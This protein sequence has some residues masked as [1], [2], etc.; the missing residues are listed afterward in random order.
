METTQFLISIVKSNKDI[1]NILKHSKLTGT[2]DGN[3]PI[4]WYFR[5]FYNTLKFPDRIN[6]SLF[7]NILPKNCQTIS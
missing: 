5:R 2:M 4:N 6:R 1:L 3:K 7:Y